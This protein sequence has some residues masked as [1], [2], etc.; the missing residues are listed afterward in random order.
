LRRADE[1][2]FDAAL[3]ALP[4]PAQDA[5]LASIDVDS[6]ACRLWTIVRAAADDAARDSALRRAMAVLARGPYCADAGAEAA[7]RL[8]DAASGRD[9]SLVAA[10][11]SACRNTLGLSEE[12]GTYVGDI[13]MKFDERPDPTPSRSVGRA[14]GAWPSL[15]AELRAYVAALDAGDVTLV[16]PAPSG[17]FDAKPTWT[18]GGAHGPLVSGVE[19]PVGREYDRFDPDPSFAL[20]GEPTGAGWRFT[21]TNRGQSQVAVPTSLFAFSRLTTVAV[22]VPPTAASP[23]YRAL[24]IDLR[25][26]MYASVVASRLRVLAPDE[27]VAWTVAVPEDLRACEHV[28]VDFTSWDRVTGTP[29]APVLTNWLPTWVR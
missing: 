5:A 9:A 10:M 1:K 20:K 11:K 12:D 6:A 4:P 16:D 22:Y 17:F 14:L 2:R 25:P 19:P 21:L 24:E 26:G 15:A 28:R 27:S 8:F 23:T 7:L 3:A 29:A 13:R 18:E